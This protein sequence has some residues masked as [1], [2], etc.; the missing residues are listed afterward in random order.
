MWT[1]LCTGLLLS[2]WWSSGGTSALVNIMVSVYMLYVYGMCIVWC[3]HGVCV[4][5]GVCGE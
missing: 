3:V 5:Y 2:V 1:G 4:L